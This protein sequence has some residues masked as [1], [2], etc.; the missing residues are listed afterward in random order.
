V[1]DTIEPERC[2]WRVAHGRFIR[3]CERDSTTLIE[4]GEL[5]ARVCAKCLERARAL[6]WLEVAG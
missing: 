1:T 6:G 2:A 3:T 4:H 5:R